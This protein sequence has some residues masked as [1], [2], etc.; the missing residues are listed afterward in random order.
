MLICFSGLG[1]SFI[2]VF[3][4]LFKA[5]KYADEKIKITFNNI[6][7]ERENHIIEIMQQYSDE[8]NILQ[9]KKIVVL[10]STE[11]EDDFLGTFFKSFGFNKK[12]IS[13]L[14]VDAYQAIKDYDLLF[15]N[16]ETDDLSKDLIDEF[17]NNSANNSVLFYFNTTHNNYINEKISD[18]LSFANTRTQIYGNLINLLK[19]QKVLSNN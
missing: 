5:R 3:G 6:I 10:S 9:T 1:L 4:F 18:K 8:I 16:N 14:K 17:F 11:G 7:E 12:N 13:F 2:L 15:A 19:F